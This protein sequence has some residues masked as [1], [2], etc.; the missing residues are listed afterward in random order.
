MAVVLIPDEK[1]ELHDPREI[2]EFLQPFGIVHQ[3]WPLEERVD[4]GASPDE[5]LKAYDPE[6][7][8][9]KKSGGYVVADVIAIT[10]ETPNLDALLAKFDK[11]H[12]HSEDE[13]RFILKGRGLFHVRPDNGPVFAI[14]VE[15]GDLINVPKNTKHWFNLC[16]EKT[17]RAIRLFQET[18]GW[19]PHYVPDAS[20]SRYAPLCWG[21]Q[22][23]IAENPFTPAVTV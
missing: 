1:R 6:I 22:Q 5:I 21:P 8:A 20:H 16:R 12:T 3:R 13:V 23:V 10:P 11:E 9:L 14:E 7:E 19:T 4:P 2:N 15:A 17:I 18:A